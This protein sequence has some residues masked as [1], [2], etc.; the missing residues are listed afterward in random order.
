MGNRWSLARGRLVIAAAGAAGAAAGCG[1]PDEIVPR[2]LDAAEIDAVL[3]IDARTDAA[4]DGR[5]ALP[6]MVLVES[7]MV[8]SIQVHDLSFDV[9]SCELVEGCIG[10]AGARRLLRFSTVTANAGNGDLYF[11]PPESNP[12]FEYSVCHGH[13]HFSGYAAY[14]LVD[15]TGV[16]VTGHK[17]A[18]CLLDTFQVDPDRPGPYYTCV[19]QGISAGWADSYPAFLPCQWIDITTVTPGAY[20]LRVRINPDQLF[21]ESD[22]TNN[23]LD[24]P[25]VF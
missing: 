15:G 5:P 10:G 2:P 9:N 12:L 17:Q 20:T 8:G 24:I 3:P 13:H 22:Y 1:G 18:F 21:E 4:S 14:E 16:V 6:D 25:V 7:L 23:Q 11:G 19:N